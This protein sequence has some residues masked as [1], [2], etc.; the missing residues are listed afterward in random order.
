MRLFGQV[1]GADLAFGVP[2][3]EP[4][5]H[6]GEAGGVEAV[7]AGEEPPA[8]PLERI[9]VAASVAE[10]V[11]LVRRRTSSSAVLARRITWK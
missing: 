3:V 8:D 2:G 10:G 4:G 7:M 9:G 11:V 6:A 5:E 1:G